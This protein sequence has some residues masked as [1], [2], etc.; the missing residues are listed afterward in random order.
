MQF[1]YNFFN[2][3]DDV[4]EWLARYLEERGA[5]VLGNTRARRRPSDEPHYGWLNNVYNQGLFDFRLR[6]GDVNRFLLGFYGRLA[7]GMS[8]HV[9]S[10]SEGSPFIYYNTKLGGF[11]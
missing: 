11:T 3:G 7:Y 6:G 9:Y 4:G 5:F 1:Q 2:P 10:A 8:R